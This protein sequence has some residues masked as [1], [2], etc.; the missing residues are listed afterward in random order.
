M[1][2]NRYELE[3][4]AR[5]CHEANRAMQHIQNDPAPS[6]PWDAESDLVRKAAVNLIRMVCMGHTNEQIHSEW[7][8]RY[9]EEGWRCGPVKDAALKTHPCLM[10][11]YD[12]PPLQRHK[13][14]VIR[15]IV[16]TLS[17]V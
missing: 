6:L 5:V 13:T 7:C 16:V 4:I 10:P 8:D 12:L 1:K 14:E 17:I 15:S 9:R 3:E 2:D 11:Y